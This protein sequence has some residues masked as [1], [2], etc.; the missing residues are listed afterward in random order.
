[1]IRHEPERLNCLSGTI[2]W[3]SKK[4][5]LNCLY[6]N[7]TAKSKTSEILGGRQMGGQSRLLQLVG[8]ELKE[9]Y[10]MKETKQHKGF[11]SFRS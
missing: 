6:T 7:H 8:T 5:L 1:M 10:K 3:F 11:A 4:A 2:S 9:A